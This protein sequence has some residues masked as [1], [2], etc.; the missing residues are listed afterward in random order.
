MILFEILFTTTLLAYKTP[1]PL[2]NNNKIFLSI[3]NFNKNSHFLR[4]DNIHSVKPRLSRLS[5]L[6][7]NNEIPE[8]SEV[9]NSQI[10]E[11]SSEDT[12]DSNS[13]D[14][15]WELINRNRVNDIN[16]DGDKTLSS[17]S[18]TSQTRNEISENNKGGGI[19]EVKWVGLGVAGVVRRFIC[20]DA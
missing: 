13:G 16:K 5:K 3:K 8:R 10:I 7:S 19:G 18:N 2:C 6:N 15:V 11:K 1:T 20:V 12:D 9:I 17:T 14:N 4:H